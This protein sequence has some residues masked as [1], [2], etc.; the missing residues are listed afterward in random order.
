MVISPSSIFVSSGPRSPE[1]IPRAADQHPRWSPQKNPNMACCCFLSAAPR[2][3]S[4]AVPGSSSGYTMRT[5]SRRPRSLVPPLLFRSRCPL[6]PFVRAFPLFRSLS[7]S[8]RSLPSPQSASRDSRYAGFS[9]RVASLA[10]E[11]S[12]ARMV[13]FSF[14]P[15]VVFVLDSLF[16]KREM[17]A[18][19]CGGPLFWTTSERRPVPFKR[20]PWISVR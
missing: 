12:G 4:W 2:S 20:V 19:R 8:C 13:I 16:P 17:L 6:V 5:P 14:I 15:Y 10:P 11:L 3:R 1:K 18:G 9:L 7:T